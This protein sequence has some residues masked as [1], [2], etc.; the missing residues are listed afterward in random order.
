YED[1]AQRIDALMDEVGAGQP[2]IRINDEYGVEHTVWTVTD[3]EKVRF[4]QTQM[5]D[6]K[7]IIADGHHRYETALAYR[8]EM[9]GENGSDRIPMTFFKMDSPGLTIL[10]THRVLANVPGF[11]PQTLLNDAADFLSTTA[12]QG[13]WR[14]AFADAS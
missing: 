9:R 13:S 1:P 8:D 12:S 5:A 4:I 6:K 3:A 7:L 10:P 11:N 14:V 2:D